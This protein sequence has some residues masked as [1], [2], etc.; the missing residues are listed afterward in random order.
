MPD[1]KYIT[2]VDDHTMFRKGLMSLINLFSNYEVLFDAANG[3][4]FIAQLNPKKLP[5][6]VLLDISMLEMDGY[7]TAAWIRD[8]YPGIKNSCAQYNG[9]RNGY[10]KN[11]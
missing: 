6:I 3:K 8:N 2:V 4:D 9:C 5:D 1:T 7:E 11:D 10:H